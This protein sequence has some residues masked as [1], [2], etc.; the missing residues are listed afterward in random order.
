[1]T[2]QTATKDWTQHKIK[3]FGVVSTG[4]TPSTKKKEYYGGNYKLISPAD[5]TDSKYI[6]TSHKLIT[7]EGLKVS[8]TLPRNS[9]LVGCIG[10]VGKIGMT[11]DEVSA[12]NQQIN[13]ITCNDNF[14]A[15]FVYYLLRE[16]RT[17]LESKSAK[18]TLP[19]LNKSNFENIDFDVPNLPEQ[20]VIA[21]TLTTVQDAIAEQE[22]LI[23]KLKELKRSMM[24]HL[25]THGI[26]G[27]RTKMT[28][29]GEVP[30]SW[31]VKKLGD[32]CETSSGGTPSRTKKNYYSGDILWIKSG[33]MNDGYINN[34][35]EKITDDAVKNSSAKLFEA[36]TLLVAMYGA[37]AGRTAILSHEATTN[38]A[39]C[40]IFMNERVNLEFV[41]HV[42]ILQRDFILDQ[43]HGGAQPNL[44]QTSIRNLLI[45]LP[46]IDEQ[47]KIA[48][49]LVAVEKKIESTQG[50]L[51][52]YQHLFKT[53]LHELMSGERRINKI[54]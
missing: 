24:Q 40:G 25:F 39:V 17:I 9:V 49:S 27:E 7:E 50:K 44:S 47:N 6:Q 42:L 8:R 54:L 14:N 37:T 5:L 48:E 19:I 3:D 45:P 15:D 28:E 22:K 51:L 46:V 31:E 29:I 52:S 10:N 33:E 38:Q 43:R 35:E 20:K 26:K 34:S 4:N 30:E 21:Q 36:G 53:L 23:A 11:V 18:V 32:I 2:T 41:R 1:M 16:N 12:F 13:A